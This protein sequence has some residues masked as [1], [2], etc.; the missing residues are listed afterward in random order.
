MMSRLSVKNSMD[1]VP[2]TES[3]ELIDIEAAAS[4]YGCQ[5][6]RIQNFIVR[7][8]LHPLF[9]MHEIVELRQEHLRKQVSGNSNQRQKLH[10]GDN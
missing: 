10:C 9:D 8:M 3:H 4:L 6:D 5:C 2:L 7:G 1:Y